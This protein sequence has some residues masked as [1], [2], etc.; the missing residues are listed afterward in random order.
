MEAD[1][2]ILGYFC[3]SSFDT[4]VNIIA[5]MWENPAYGIREENTDQKVKEFVYICITTTLKYC[6]QNNLAKWQALST[7]C[8]PNAF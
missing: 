7:L 6:H 5:M 2:T 3:D 8:G 4:S 1:L